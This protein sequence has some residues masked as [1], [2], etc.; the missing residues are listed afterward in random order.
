[1]AD[2]DPLEYTFVGSLPELHRAEMIVHSLMYDSKSVADFEAEV[3][4]EE[5]EHTQSKNISDAVANAVGEVIPD[6]IT[7]HTQPPPRPKKK[8]PPETQA[9]QKIRTI[10]AD[11]R[12]YVT[13]HPEPL[14]IFAVPVVLFR[15]EYYFDGPT[16][17]YFPP[18]SKEEFVELAF[19]P[20]EYPPWP[21]E[22]GFDQSA[23]E[24]RRKEERGS[25]AYLR[26]IMASDEEYSRAVEMTVAKE[27][28]EGSL[29]AL[30]NVNVRPQIQSLDDLKGKVQTITETLRQ[31]GFQNFEVH[32][33]PCRTRYI[34]QLHHDAGNE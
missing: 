22:E 29:Y 17:R 15:R 27:L 10:A 32:S 30:L 26:V 8:A 9:Q 4:A 12:K 24:S 21:G 34:D 2:V 3:A 20:G 1:M 14:N 25:H 16:M 31:R 6:N 11:I 23:C 18:H 28:G 19:S 33:L 5:R 7:T 13:S